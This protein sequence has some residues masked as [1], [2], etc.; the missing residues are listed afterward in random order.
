MAPPGRVKIV[1]LIS[2]SKSA[3]CA[4][5]VCSKWTANCVGWVGAG[6][7]DGCSN[8][9]VTQHTVLRYTFW[10]AERR[11]EPARLRPK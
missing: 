8:D 4:L 10:Q 5:T 1:L 11:A 9:S 3:K 2:S 6:G 7:C